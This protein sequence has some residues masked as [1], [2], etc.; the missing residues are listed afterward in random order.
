MTARYGGQAPMNRGA[1]I[2]FAPLWLVLAGI[3]EL[4]PRRDRARVRQ[5]EALK[6]PTHLFARSHAPGARA[7]SGALIRQTP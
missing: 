4:Q 3:T 5:P 7:I 1:T 6:K 2:V